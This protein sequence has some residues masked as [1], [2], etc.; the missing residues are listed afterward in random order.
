MAESGRNSQWPLALCGLWL[1][2]GFSGASTLAAGLLHWFDG[3][4]EWRAALA[5]ALLGGLLATVGWRR[6]RSVLEQARRVSAV[7]IDGPRDQ[8]SRALQA[9]RSRRT[10]QVASY[11]NATGPGAQ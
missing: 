11:L 8:A 5:L 1:V 3:E 9:Y 2:V 7:A 6:S 4:L 10:G